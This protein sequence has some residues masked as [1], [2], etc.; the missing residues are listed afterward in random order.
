MSAACQAFQT[1]TLVL[2]DTACKI[3]DNVSFEQASTIPM[4]LNTVLTGLYTNLKLPETNRG[5]EF[6][7]QYFLVWGASTS[8]GI[9]VIQIARSLGFT[10]IA[11][12]SPRNF[13]YVKSFG[14][15]HVFDYKD[16]EVVSKIR[17]A[18]NNSLQYAY[19]CPAQDMSTTEPISKALRDEGGV[20]VSSAVQPKPV[21]E[22][23]RLILTSNT[24]DIFKVS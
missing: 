15:E 12:A 8:I 20:I 14:A 2:A 17:Q 21:P 6:K 3:P 18:S 16:P 9:I 24:W 7:G 23:V 22:N 10:V 19:D 11:T 1:H 13:E 5:D 4:A